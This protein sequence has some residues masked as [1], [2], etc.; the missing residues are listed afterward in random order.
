MPVIWIITVIKRNK[1]CKHKEFYKDDHQIKTVVT[2]EAM[3][4][5]CAASKFVLA[6]NIQQ[7]KSVSSWQNST[8][9]F[10]VVYYNDVAPHN[11]VQPI[12]FPLN[13]GIMV[14]LHELVINL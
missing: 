5:I 9:I 4:P 6:N 1:S 7:R 2:D 12:Q 8:Q 14:D 13:S 11:K 10:A 3:D